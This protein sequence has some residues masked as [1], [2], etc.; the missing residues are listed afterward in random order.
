[1]IW[2]HDLFF[3]VFHK[4][5]KIGIRWII[6]CILLKFLVVLDSQNSE[7]WMSNK[8]ICYVFYYEQTVKSLVTLRF[9]VTKHF[10]NCNQFFMIFFLI[11]LA[12][13]LNIFYTIWKL[14]N[15]GID[16]FCFKWI[17][18]VQMNFI[19]SVLSPVKRNHQQ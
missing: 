3:K 10:N 19:D 1:M 6:D 5:I 17:F 7:V 2:F 13:F 11:K 16:F 18:S 9:L 14:K 15:K 4:V 8:Y 12:H